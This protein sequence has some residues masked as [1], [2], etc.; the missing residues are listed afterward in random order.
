MNDNGDFG[1]DGT[2]TRAQACVVMCNL[3]GRDVTA[4]QPQE[5][6]EPEQPAEPEHAI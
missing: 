2:M 4:G 5:P 1:G 6:T 3:L